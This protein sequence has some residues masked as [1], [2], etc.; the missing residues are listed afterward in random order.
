VEVKA[1]TSEGNSRDYERG[2]YQVVKY[3]AVLEAQTRI[4][5]PAQ[6]PQVHVILALEMALPDTLRPVAKALGIRVI[7]NV[8]EIPE[9][10][11]A[12]NKRRVAPRG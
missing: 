7:E 12:K 10:A 2:L 3:R 4:E 6:P 1:S 8:G 5:Q 9:F 11:I